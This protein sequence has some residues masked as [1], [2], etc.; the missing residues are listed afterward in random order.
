VGSRR[1]I[2]G[3][4]LP[5]RYYEYVYTVEHH[6][7]NVRLRVSDIHVAAPLTTHSSSDQEMIEHPAEDRSAKPNPE[8]RQWRLPRDGN[9]M[10]VTYCSSVT[11]K[12]KTP[13]GHS[14]LPKS[15]RGTQKSWCQ[16]F[17]STLHG[18]KMPGLIRH[19]AHSITNL[20]LHL[21]VA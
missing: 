5:A 11:E 21:P 1:G 20:F 17:P 16:K 9:H 12:G 15:W 7:F 3:S 10:I 14:Q 4:S 18:K 6:F 8:V 2:P 19:N 13:M